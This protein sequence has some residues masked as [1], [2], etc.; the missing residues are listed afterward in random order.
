MKKTIAIIFSA[1]FVFAATVISFDVGTSEAAAVT[2]TTGEKKIKQVSGEVTAIDLEKKSIM[3]EGITIY[4]VEGITT[5][6][7]ENM[8]ADIKVGDRVTVD[9]ITK[10]MNTAISIMRELR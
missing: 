2:K 9:Y 8:L 6:A 4:I 10:G 1:L 7:D 3:V 5:E